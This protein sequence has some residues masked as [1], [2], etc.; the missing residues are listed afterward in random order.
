MSKKIAVIG[1]CMIELSQKGAEVSRGFG[2][3]TLNTSVYIARQVAPEALAVNYVTALGTDS[4]SQQMLEAWQSENVGTALIQRMENR[5]P[6]LYYIETDS[7]GERTFYY[8]RNEAAAKFWLESENSAAI[9]E[10]LATF[11]YL[12]LSGIS[13]AIL[14]PSSRE[15]LLSLLHECRAN[16]GKVIFDNNYRPRLWASREETQQVYQ[17]M[18]NCTDIAFLTLDDEDAL[19]GE[20]PVEEVIARTHQAGVNEVVIKRGAD[21]CLVSVNGEAVVD[22]PAVKLAKQKV[23]D[24][25]AAGD[26]FSAGYLAV[27]L[28]GGTPAEAA[29]LGH[30]TAST[31]IQYRGAIIP[32]EAMPG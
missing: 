21:S 9:C 8:W 29:K 19:W 1:E 6:G 4:F 7:T 12:Y 10:E 24:T 25:T 16:G 11:D 14:S 27:R 28:T 26:S 22:V 5:L 30:L 13:L 23:V 31:V 17:Q 15:K 3:D 32:R 2:G 20:K 18:L